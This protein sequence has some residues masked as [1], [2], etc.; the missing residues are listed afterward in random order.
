MENENQ[1]TQPVQSSRSNT[2]LSKF[3][4][5][6]LRHKPE[7]VGLTLDEHGWADVEKLLTA[8]RRSGRMIN[9]E[10]LEEIVRTDEKKRYTLSEDGRK[11][12]AA[13]GHSISVD[14]ELKEQIPPD[15][16]YHGTS[17]RFLDNIFKDGLLPQSRQYVHLSKD[18]ETAVKVGARH[19]NAIVLRVEAGNMHQNGYAFYLSENG[20]WLTK[21]VPTEYLKVEGKN[22]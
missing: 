20:I 14:L 21:K 19:G 8:V 9:R 22:E 2:K 5:L 4:C 12:R 13:Q 10:I 18:F 16:L 15:I 6:V 3:L 1:S 11:I 7:T 17:T